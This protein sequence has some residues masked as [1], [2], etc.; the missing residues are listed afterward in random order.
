MKITKQGGRI[1]RSKA[2]E[3]YD[4][5]TPEGW[6]KRRT[7]L[8]NKGAVL[9]PDPITTASVLEKK[10]QARYYEK[11]KVRIR[12]LRRLKRQIP[13]HA[14]KK[15]KRAAEYN[16]ISWN[17]S[18]EEWFSLWENVPKVYDRD[19][20]FFRTAYSLRGAHVNKCTQMGRLSMDKGFELGNIVI[21]YK[22]QPIPDSGV[23][24]DWDMTNARPVEYGRV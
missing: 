20:G 17:L 15:A 10:R 24:G 16:K 9:P 23:V 4:T 18:Y 19:S 8:Q 5:S 13:Q 1:V 22:N 11:H 21:L 6:R 14:Y 12:A 3:M 7:M 2:G